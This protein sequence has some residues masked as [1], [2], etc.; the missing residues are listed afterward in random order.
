MTNPLKG[1][2]DLQLGNKSYPARLT[3]DSIMQI[4]MSVGC[5]IIKLAQKLSEGDIRMSDIVFVLLPALKGGGSNITEKD[6]KNII[7]DIGLVESA[8]AVAELLT[9]SL[10]SDSDEEGEEE[11]KKKE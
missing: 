1:Q 11:G 6:I 3:V 10:V 8:K 4:E 7:T 2:I 9:L 5:G